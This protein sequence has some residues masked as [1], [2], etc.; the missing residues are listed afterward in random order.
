M[1]NLDG[2][3]DDIPFKASIDPLSACHGLVSER[4]GKGRMHADFFTTCPCV[5]AHKST[6]LWRRSED[7]WFSL[8]GP[9]GPSAELLQSSA[10]DQMWSGEHDPLI[11]DVV[12]LGK[13]GGYI[14]TTGGGKMLVLLCC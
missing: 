5:K 3:T 8:L 1:Q 10:S 7:L 12:V 11:T 13:G 6:R 9:T 4:M 14:K 2:E